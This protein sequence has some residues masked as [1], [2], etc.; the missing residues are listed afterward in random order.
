M[1][2]TDA[3]IRAA[4]QQAVAH[5]NGDAFGAAERLLD[6]ILTARP[7]LP[8]ALMLMGA[9]RL[10]Q[11]RPG[12]AEMLLRQALAQSPDQPAVLLQLGH[13]LRAQGRDGDAL[14]AYRQVIAQIPHHGEAGLALAALLLERDEMALAATTARQALPAPDPALAAELHTVLGEALMRQHLVD[15]AL[16]AFD[17]AL[18]LVPHAPAAMRGRAT[19]LEH[20]G[21]SAAAETAYRAILAREPLDLKTHTLLNELLHRKGDAAGF[22][23]SYDEAAPQQP[24]LLTAK[25][26]QLLKLDRPQEALDAFE[27][28]LRLSPD[29]AT[30]AGKGR[31]LL[32]LGDQDRAVAAF[33]A[34]L[35][36]HPDHPGLQTAFAYGL[37]R[38]GDARR[39]QHLVEQ[40]LTRTPHS[41]PALSVLGLCYRANNDAREAGLNGFDDLVQVFD[42]D[43]PPGFPDNMAFHDALARH[44]DG[45]HAGAQAFFSQTLRGGTRSF[46][47]FFRYSH[48][49]RDALK[50]TIRQALAR[51]I[52]QMAD[53]PDHPFL[54]RRARDFAFSGSWSSRMQDGGYHLNHIHDGWISAVYYVA[55]P[56]V[57]A[58][59]T[60]MQ[61]WLKFGE[62]SAAIGLARPIRRVVQPVPGRLVLFPSYTWHGTVPYHSPQPR[63]T[64]AF[65]ILPR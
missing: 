57:T 23:R 60:M 22:L 59:A 48:A 37:L 15:D 26:E 27:R 36:R 64:I 63:T 20:K 53:Q 54:G 10:S 3:E 1:G 46:D 35:A 7:Q 13:A 56:D 45:L 16:A 50:A 65:D 61:G 52:R 5:L 40:A 32:A 41:Q 19:T 34:G 51:Y 21:D 25:A 29:A 9:A 4:L 12:D 42:L 44:L 8:Q 58:D 6:T 30:H 17:A 49:L 62:P 28:A 2:V 47:E 39:A 43:P 31:A 38:I 18:Q 33:E 24:A 55:V 14:A 11:A